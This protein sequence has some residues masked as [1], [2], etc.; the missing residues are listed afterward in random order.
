MGAAAA[1][2]DEEGSG[3]G[4]EGGVGG[5]IRGDTGGSTRRVMIAMGKCHC[6]VSL[7]Y[8]EM[9]CKT[10]H[11]N[12]S[13]ETSCFIRLPENCI[14]FVQTKVYTRNQVMVGTGSKT[15]SRRSGEVE[16]IPKQ[17]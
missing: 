16:T 5:R 10:F 3:G 8:S 9:K 2:V 1:A 17:N 6:I 15:S 12:M 14:L 11:F 4:E 7:N 13:T